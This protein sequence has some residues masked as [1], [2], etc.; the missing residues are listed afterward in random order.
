MNPLQN[1][2]IAGTQL[3]TIAIVYSR[4]LESW[5]DLS[6]GRILMGK[7][8]WAVGEGKLTSISRP[9]EYHWLPQTVT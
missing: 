7:R 1:A 3:E 8:C 4:I 6:V 5:V 9:L 2:L